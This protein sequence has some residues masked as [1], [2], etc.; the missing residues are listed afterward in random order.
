MRQRGWS[1]DDYERWLSGAMI[2]MVAPPVPSVPP[3]P[4]E[5]AQGG[6]RRA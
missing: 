1:L 6:R 3:V 2:A 5:G 4:P